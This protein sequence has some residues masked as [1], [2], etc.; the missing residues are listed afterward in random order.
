MKNFFIRTHRSVKKCSLLRII[1]RETKLE[2]HADPQKKIGRDN[3]N[4]TRAIK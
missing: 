3:Y 1:K 4:I 2:E